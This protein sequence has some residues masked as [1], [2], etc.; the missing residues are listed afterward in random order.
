MDEGRGTTAHRY[1]LIV[2][3]QISHWSSGSDL[4]VRNLI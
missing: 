1:F 2:F 4:K 3:N